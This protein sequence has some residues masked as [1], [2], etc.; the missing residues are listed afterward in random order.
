MIISG[1]LHIATAY[2]C[3]I[4]RESAFHKEHLQRFQQSVLLLLVAR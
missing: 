1:K 2:K 4:D 3:N